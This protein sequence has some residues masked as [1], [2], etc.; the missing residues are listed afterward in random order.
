MFFITLLAMN[1]LYKSYVKTDLASLN[2]VT[3]IE[4]IAIFP[5][6]AQ[7]FDSGDFMNN[8]MKKVIEGKRNDPFILLEKHFFAAGLLYKKNYKVEFKD[9]TYEVLEFFSKT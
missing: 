5:T 8:S 2:Y 9:R 1:H 4:P 6:E 7:F 3:F